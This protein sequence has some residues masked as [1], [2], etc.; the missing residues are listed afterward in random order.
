M[1]E[2]TQRTRRTEVRGHLGELEL[3]RVER[4]DGRPEGLALLR[5][6]HRALH[7]QVKQEKGREWVWEE[8][9]D[10][11]ARLHVQRPTSSAACAMPR[12][13]AAIPMRPASSVIMAILK[14][15]PGA[16]SRFACMHQHRRI[17]GCEKVDSLRQMCVVPMQTLQTCA[18]RPCPLVTFFDLTYLGHAHVLEDEVGGGGGADAE[19]VLP[20][21]HRE[22]RGIAGHHEGG[23]AWWFCVVWPGGVG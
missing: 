10:T 2:G 11:Q 17:L 8:R 22:A 18:S 21:P 19:L 5:V 3:D 20:L 7:E 9:Q 14:P 1:H 13:W 6:L 23:D 15:I 12:D 16:P 4:G